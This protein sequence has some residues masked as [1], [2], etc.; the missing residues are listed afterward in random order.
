M[1]ESVDINT[2]IGIALGYLVAQLIRYLGRT[3]F[4]SAIRDQAQLALTD[5]SVAVDTPRAAAERA[6][7]DAQRSQVE[8]V[9]RSLSPTN[10]PAATSGDDDDT[11]RLLRPVDKRKE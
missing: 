11:P 5:P 10:P 2:V 9:A 3:R 8:R 7:V 6:L 1:T 4:W